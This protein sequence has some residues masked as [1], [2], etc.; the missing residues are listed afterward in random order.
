[1]SANRWAEDGEAF[2][3]QGKAQT[4]AMAAAMA[5]ICNAAM[6][7]KRP[8]ADP[9]YLGTSSPSSEASPA[10]PRASS[11]AGDL[12]RSGRRCSRGAFFA[13]FLGRPRKQVARG[14]VRANGAAKQIPAGSV[15]YSHASLLPSPD[16]GARRTQPAPE[17]NSTTLRGASSPKKRWWLSAVWPATDVL[18]GNRLRSYTSSAAST[19]P[20]WAQRAS[21]S[22]APS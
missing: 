11:I 3:T 8:P 20:G 1:M 12:E 9:T 17:N 2:G 5:R 13:Y 16:I 4:T 7:P 6:W 10:R 15:P 22:S 19:W 14:G 21:P 18:R